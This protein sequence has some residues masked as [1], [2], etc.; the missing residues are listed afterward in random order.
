MELLACGILLVLIGAS[1]S[2]SEFLTPPE[3]S[4]TS[5]GLIL[6]IATNSTC[7]LG[8]AYTITNPNGPTNQSSLCTDFNHISNI[9]SVSTS[10][11]SIP[12]EDHVLIRFTSQV[13]SQI[14]L[15]NTNHLLYNDFLCP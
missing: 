10:W 1:P 13:C 7:Q 14:S 12:G 9:L 4:L 15:Y 8:E 3:I 6:D 5:G 2:E 11:R